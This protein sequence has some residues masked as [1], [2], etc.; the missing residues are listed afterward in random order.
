QSI[1]RTGDSPHRARCHLGIAGGV[2]E[3]GVPEQRLDDADIDAVL[4]Q[5]CG[6]AV[7]QCVRADASRDLASLGGFDHDAIELPCADG[8]EGMLARKQPAIA[9]QHTLAMALLPPLAQ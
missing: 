2:L 9:M 7:P 6:K 3:L 5:V 8:L 1:K 4:E